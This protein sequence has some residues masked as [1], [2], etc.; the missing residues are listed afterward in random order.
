[1]G[2]DKLFTVGSAL[3]AEPL[4]KLTLKRPNRRATFRRNAAVNT[5]NEPR[6]LPAF[7]A[8]ISIQILGGPPNPPHHSTSAQPNVAANAKAR[9]LQQPDIPLSL[10]LEIAS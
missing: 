2:E 3:R 10:S 8:E 9:R 5:G 7:P 6:V 1:M 4:P